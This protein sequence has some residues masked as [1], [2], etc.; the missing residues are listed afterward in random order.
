M[1][2]LKTSKID[3][4]KDEMYIQHGNNDFLVQRRQEIKLITN[5]PVSHLE[6][7]FR[8]STLAFRKESKILFY[9][10]R[11]SKANLET[12]KNSEAFLEEVIGKNISDIMDFQFMIDFF[13]ALK[14]FSESI[15]Y[16]EPIRNLEG[17]R[18]VKQVYLD[19][20]LQIYG[21]S[22]VFELVANF[23]SAA[24]FFMPNARFQLQKMFVNNR[25]T[26]LKEIYMKSKVFANVFL[27]TVYKYE[28]FINFDH[29]N[30]ETSIV[31]KY[32]ILHL[33]FL[34]YTVNT[35]GQI[36]IRDNYLYYFP[37]IYDIFLEIKTNCSLSMWCDSGFGLKDY[38][39]VIQLTSE[40]KKYDSLLILDNI[41]DSKFLKKIEGAILDFL[42]YV[43]KENVSVDIDRLLRH[44]DIIK[45]QPR[46]FFIEIP[47]LRKKRLRAAKS[48]ISEEKTYQD[49]TNHENL[50][51]PKEETDDYFDSY[52]N[53]VQSF[54]SD[55][56]LSED[57]Q[58][59]LKTY[60]DF[61]SISAIHKTVNNTNEAEN[62]K[63]MHSKTNKVDSSNNIQKVDTETSKVEV[64]SV[65]FFKEMRKMSIDL[66]EQLFFLMNKREFKPVAVHNYWNIDKI[67]LDLHAE[68]Q[69]NIRKNLNIIKHPEKYVDI[70]IEL[71]TES[72][73]EWLS[74]KYEGFYLA[75]IE[76]I[77]VQTEYDYQSTV[78]ILQEVSNGNFEV[79]E[80]F[81]EQA[82]DSDDNS[83]INQDKEAV[84]GEL[85][86]EYETRDSERSDNKVHLGN[87]S[88]ENIQTKD[89][90]T[91]YD[92]RIN[93][94]LLDRS[95]SDSRKNADKEAFDNVASY[96]SNDIE[97][98]HVV[99][100]SATDYQKFADIQLQKRTKVVDVLAKLFDI[101]SDTLACINNE[102]NT[103]SSIIKKI[104][105]KTASVVH[106]V[107]EVEEYEEEELETILVKTN[108]EVEIFLSYDELVIWKEIFPNVPNNI[109]K[110][111]Y[112]EANGKSDLLLNDLESYSQSITH[113]NSSDSITYDFQSL[114]EEKV[115]CLNE[116]L[117]SCNDEHSHQITDKT[118]T[119]L[120]D[121]KRDFPTI[122]KK[123]SIVQKI[124]NLTLQ[125]AE[126]SLFLSNYD[127]SKAVLRCVLSYQSLYTDLKTRFDSITDVNG[128]DES[129]NL[130]VC[131]FFDTKKKASPKFRQPRYYPRK[132][133]IVHP[134]EVEK[135][136]YFLK[137]IQGL[138]EFR[139]TFALKV[140][141]FF[142][143]DVQ[144]SINLLVLLRKLGKTE[145]VNSETEFLTK[146]DLIPDLQPYIQENE[147]VDNEPLGSPLIKTIEKETTRNIKKRVKKV[148]EVE[149]PGPNKDEN[150]DNFDIC[151]HRDI[152]DD[153]LFELLSTCMISLSD[154]GRVE[155]V[156]L[157]DL[158]VEKWW[159]EEL[160]QRQIKCYEPDT[161]SN[162]TLCHYVW[163]LDI[164]KPPE[165]DD[166]FYSEDIYSLVCDFL[167]S[168]D[169][170]IID[171]E[172]CIEVIGKII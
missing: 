61:H 121:Q 110:E 113:S 97:I 140:L 45:L 53:D 147:F 96:N 43:I 152:I 162:Y 92:S 84:I 66:L 12:V 54:S 7:M 29:L 77:L 73:I 95:E 145:Y 156:L 72:C 171:K 131:K 25:A 130:I 64:I 108:E 52:A 143:I 19:L 38:L 125:F 170:L 116:A 58:D 132:T 10:S 47:A 138:D 114:G 65:Y 93:T 21:S 135:Y 40:F 75:D 164:T 103:T 107:R 78:E 111:K 98:K 32:I 80:N 90:L 88:V 126:Y 134:E 154:L 160:R 83:S 33:K 157:I 22:Q 23:F 141:E 166:Q 106:P 91:G 59:Y 62:Y 39:N 70:V 89:K 117:I 49:E 87:D 17:T 161:Q 55:E 151:K 63:K 1:R 168:K 24:F 3:S 18:Q 118:L 57:D 48:K 34:K 102:N 142:N 144:A 41:S 14:T 169:F 36:D 150:C 139:S 153:T 112:Y 15:D 74:Y 68:H 149:K 128:Y 60:L 99:N 105:Q 4:R 124:L 26:L 127:F 16:G 51:T 115:T 69:V 100:S 44:P 148:R 76:S 42:N 56:V 86:E 50:P 46:Y 85:S 129:L 155:S 2:Q 9:N 122:K 101:D 167:I 165:A 133:I 94:A 28:D 20:I 11:K 30:F 31:L 71:D 37:D 119:I 13:E 158:S 67:I 5:R 163:P 81:I 27:V 172:S 8:K 123:V 109:L 104:W 146:N 82:E 79:L 6:N 120:N 137:N 35:S 159:S 136:L